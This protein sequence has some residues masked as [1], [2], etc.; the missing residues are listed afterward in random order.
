MVELSYGNG[1]FLELVRHGQDIDYFAECASELAQI[2]H[3][4]RL[5][6]IL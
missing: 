1:S 4:S 2:K 3:L 6:N 5:F